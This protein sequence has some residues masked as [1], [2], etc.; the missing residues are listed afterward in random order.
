MGA[1]K[2]LLIRMSEQEFYT[3]PEN[4]RGYLQSKMVTPEMNDWSELMEDEL[5]AS[6]YKS[7][8]KV[9]KDLDQRAYDLREQRRKINN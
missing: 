5:Y 6:L 8:K 2:E 1:T 4:V 7:K 3:M 9:T